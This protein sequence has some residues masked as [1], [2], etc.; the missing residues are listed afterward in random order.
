MKRGVAVGKRKIELSN[1]EKVL[2]PEDSIIKAELIEYYL[3]AAPTLLRH[4]KGRPLSLVRYPDGISGQAFFQKQKPDYAPDWLAH[5]LLGEEKKTDYILATE[6]ASMVWLANQACIELHQVQCRMPHLDKPD[7]M[8]F[9]LDP[10]E[11]YDFAEL[12][13]I[14]LQ[15]REHVESLGYHAFAKTSGGKGLH[16]VVPLEPAQDYDRVFEA[17]SAIAKP[18]VTAHSSLTTLHI[19]KEARKGKV[20]VDIYRNRPS[21]TIAS[22]YSVRGHAHAPVSMPLTWNELESLRDPA[23]FNLRTALDRLL[24]EGDAW[25]TM[26]AYAAR[27]HTERSRA[28]VRRRSRQEEP[29]ESLQDYKRKR[30]FSK[31]PEPPPES[32]AG[33]G[34]AF[35]IHRHHASHLHYDLRLECD[36][37]LKSWALPKGLPPRPGVKRLAAAVE[38][39]PLSYLRFEGEIPKGQ[40]GGGHMWVF[41]MGRHDV[42]K[43]KKDGFYFRLQSRELNAE[44]RLIHTRNK[45]YILE[46]V[47]SVQVDWLRDPIAPMLAHSRATPPDSEDYLYEVKWDGIR[48]LIAIDDGSVT[49]R[50]RNQRDITRFFPE[51]LLP[52]EAFRASCAL[53]D[54]EIVCLDEEG[55]PIFEHAVHRLHVAKESAIERARRTHPAVCY[56]FDCLY[57]DGRS[58]VNEPLERRREWLEDAVRPNDTFRVSEA[59]GEGM[60]LF[61]A[62]TRIGLE[63]IMA[64]QRAGLYL[65]GKRSEAW[66]K[67]KGRQTTE[68]II[69]GYTRG[70]GDRDSSFGALH[71]GCYL[72]RRLQY[73]GKVGTGFNERQLKSLLDDLKK[74]RPGKRP[75]KERSP[76]DAETVWL[77]PELVCEVRYASHTKDGNLREPVFLRLR[78]DLV[79]EDCQG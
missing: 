55:K 20:L 70:K 75:M 26:G 61:E 23:S 53:F 30:S 24:S 39:H 11:G 63:G 9:D 36:G 73:A 57:L 66:L 45:D 4:I 62:A 10:P 48:A 42:T 64:K 67:I 49:I 41:A 43:K 27:L 32:H 2:F 5:V 3:K 33:E 1:L 37:T 60:Q 52:A 28:P 8:V 79:P 25:E 13:G 54:G 31:T 58:I 69:L 68:C 51:L 19:K 17:I 15:L 74:V 72:N 7:Y 76:D 21:Q 65:P 38:D 35:V 44:Y 12:V 16:V 18:F 50:S 78:P 47:D 29:S 40:Y 6:E 59:V 77:E 34:S 56:L 22:P 46:R 14:A 71:L